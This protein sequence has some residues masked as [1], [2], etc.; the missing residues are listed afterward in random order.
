L[1][2]LY[3]VSFF[4]VKDNPYTAP[5]RYFNELNL[6]RLVSQRILDQLVGNAVGI[7]ARESTPSSKRGLSP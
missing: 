1:L 3:G 2:L 6:G 4:G 5:A 7:G